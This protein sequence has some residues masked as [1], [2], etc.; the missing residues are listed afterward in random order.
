MHTVA[1]ASDSFFAHPE[2]LHLPL[3]TD[4]VRYQGDLLDLLILTFHPVFPSQIPTNCMS[5]Q[6]N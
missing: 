4:I 3:D 1:N 5:F 2:E 6:P